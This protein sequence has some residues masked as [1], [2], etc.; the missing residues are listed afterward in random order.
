MDFYLNKMMVF[1]TDQADKKVPNV[2]IPNLHVI[3]DSSKKIA[4]QIF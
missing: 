3:M 4:H 2:L 1:G